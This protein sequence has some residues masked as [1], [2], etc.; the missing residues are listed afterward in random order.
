MERTQGAVT[1]FER[2]ELER[3][4]LQVSFALLFLLVALLL[5]L[6]AEWIGLNFAT[7]LSRPISLL[8]GAT[9]KSANRRFDSPRTRARRVR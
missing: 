6:A 5:L 7:Q 3:A 2:L 9:E 1:Q 8:I 4:D